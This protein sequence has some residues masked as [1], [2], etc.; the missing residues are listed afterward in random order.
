M[1][2]QLTKKAQQGRPQI[3]VV[4]LEKCFHFSPTQTAAP[5]EDIGC[6]GVKAHCRL[7]GGCR[8]THRNFGTHGAYAACITAHGANAKSQQSHTD[9]SQRYRANS[10][11]ADGEDAL[12]HI[13]PAHLLSPDAPTRMDTSGR[14]KI[15]VWL[16]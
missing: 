10:R 12:G 2:A 9:Q 14:P 1:G 7:P 4:R 6:V 13:L 5:Q 11:V 15:R 16:S 3:R 8:H